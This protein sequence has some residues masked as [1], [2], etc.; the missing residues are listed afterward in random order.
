MQSNERLVSFLTEGRDLVHLR[1]KPAAHSLAATMTGGAEGE[2]R[3]G[4]PHNPS[5]PFLDCG[6]FFEP[7]TAGM[8]DSATAGGVG[9]SAIIHIAGSGGGGGGGGG[10]N[11]AGGSAASASDGSSAGA[12][13]GGGGYGGFRPAHLTRDQEIVL[14]P[15]DMDYIGSLEVVQNAFIDSI[16]R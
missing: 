3:D 13:A 7:G 9:Q 10:G 1:P 2:D 15:S 5:N 6:A 12:G 16:M 8:A 14:S 11:G 4:E